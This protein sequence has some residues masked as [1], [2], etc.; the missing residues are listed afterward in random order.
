MT[1]WLPAMKPPQEGE[2]LREGAHPQVDLVF[3][4]EE[5]GRAGTALAQHADPVGLV[6]HDPG[7]VMLR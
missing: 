6:D 5:F 4:T 7:A 1:S 2:A 3:E